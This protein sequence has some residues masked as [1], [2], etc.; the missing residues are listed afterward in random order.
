VTLDASSK[1][2]PYLGESR[3]LRLDGGTLAVE[4]AATGGASSV[5]AA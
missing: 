1:I 3:P 5:R 4:V 2:L